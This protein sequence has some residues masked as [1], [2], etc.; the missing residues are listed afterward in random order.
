M[1]LLSYIWLIA[2]IL[3]L[4]AEG[5]TMALVTIWFAGG[6]LIA[7]I[8]SLLGAPLWL[9]IVLF[10]ASSVAMLWLLFPIAKDKLNVGKAKTN[11]DAMV[12]KK[13]VITKAI[14]FN[15]IGQASI[16]GVIWSAK[17]DGDYAVGETVDITQVQ[18]NKLIVAKEII[19]G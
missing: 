9:Q 6:A 14:S 5:M 19:K 18:G 4:I 10:L 1:D 11:I 3:L 16:N 12:G 2:F 8:A 7:F 15:T 13:A 17:G